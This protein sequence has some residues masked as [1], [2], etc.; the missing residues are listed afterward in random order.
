[1]CMHI[2][3]LIY[4]QRTESEVHNLSDSPHVELPTVRGGDI[5]NH[6]ETKIK[7]L[8]CLLDSCFMITPSFN[9]GSAKLLYA[10]KDV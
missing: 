3:T 7:E 1:M 5:G 2:S 8:I 6:Y 4:S 9:R 10:M